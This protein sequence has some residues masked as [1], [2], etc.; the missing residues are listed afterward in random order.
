MSK[1]DHPNINAVWFAMKINDSMV[2]CLRGDAGKLLF[3]ILGDEEL[4]VM[5]VDFV[6]NASTRIDKIVETERRK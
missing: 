3:E 4:K 6:A 5:L 2:E 1:E